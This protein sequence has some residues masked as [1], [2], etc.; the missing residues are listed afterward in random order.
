MNADLPAYPVLSASIFLR[1]SSP[2]LALRRIAGRVRQGGHDIPPAD[3][4]RRFTRSR[5]NFET[6]YR[7]LADSWA[8]YDNSGDA[9]RLLEKGP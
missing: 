9:P 8:V 3:V 5:Q 1:L 7:L 6:A 2:V 4:L